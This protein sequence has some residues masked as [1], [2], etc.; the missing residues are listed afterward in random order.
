VEALTAGET[1]SPMPKR[2]IREQEEHDLAIR[3]IARA[4]FAGTPDWE[5]FTNPGES[6]HYALVLPDGQRIY[7]DLVARRKGAHASSYVIEVETISTVTEEEAQQW[8]ALSDL[9]RRFLLFIPAGH[10]L[11]ARELCHRFGITVHGYRVYELTPFWIRIRN[12][13]V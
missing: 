13:R 7:P 6:R 3:R 1:V 8:K 11:R 12:F 10:L 9:E 4:R 5:T 2:S